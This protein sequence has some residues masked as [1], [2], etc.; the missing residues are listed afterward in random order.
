MSAQN[1]KTAN[2][3]S[4]AFKMPKGIDKAPVHY[5][6]TFQDLSR[7]KSNTEHLLPAVQAKNLT[8]ER[9]ANSIRNKQTCVKAMQNPN[10]R[11]NS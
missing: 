11:S 8:Y 7:A 6:S 5:M 3:C 10:Y 2:K 4:V 1:S 9:A